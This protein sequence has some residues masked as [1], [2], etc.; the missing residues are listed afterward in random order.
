MR[1]LSCNA[2]NPKGAKF[3]SSCGTHLGIRCPKCG[4]LNPPGARFCN[5]CGH[6]IA[7]RESVNH[8]QSGTAP[9]LSGAEDS[10]FVPEGER[11]LVTA[12]FVDI[13]NSTGLQQDLDPEE[14]RAI[15]DPALRLMIDAVRRYDGHVVQST[16]DGI[17]ALFGA[18]VAHEDHPQRS[19]YTALRLQEEIRRFSDRLRAEGRS[20]IQ[21][22]AGANT[23][24]VVV[25]QIQTGDTQT[26]YT[27]IGHTVNLASRVQA[28]ANA[29]SIVI[30]DETRKLVE[31]YFALR[32]MGPARVKGIS[33]PID[34]YEVTGLGPLRTRLEK[35]AGRGLSKFVGRHKEKEI[36][37][38]AAELARSGSGQIVAVVAEPGV[39]K[40]RLFLEFKTEVSAA[41]T[42]LEAFS[43]SHGKGS[44][45]LPLIEL[46]HSY[47]GITSEDDGSARRERVAMK[48]GRLDSGLEN[49]LPYLHALLE[50]GNEKERLSSMDA[51]LRRSRTLEAVVRLFLSESNRYPLI[52]IVEDLQWLDDESQAVLDLLTESIGTAKVLLLVNYR[53]EY[54]LRWGSKPNCHKIRLESLGHANASEMLSAVL[55]ESR[56]LLPLKQVIIETTGGTPF[57]MEETVQALFDEGALERA[58]GSV[59]LVR[60]LA[61]LRIPPTVQAI[62]AA[63]IDR[64]HNDEKN[65]LQ[66]LAVLG[67]EFVLS[68]ARAVAG[69]SEDELE[70]LIVNLQLGEFVYEQPSI[71][72]VEY[73]FKHALTQEVAYNS[74]LLERRRQL[75]ET[76]GRAIELI[77]SAS[78]DDHV[79]DL[80]HH[81]SRS[82]NQAKAA[83]YLQLAGTQAV[84]RGALAQAVQDFETALSLLKAF[85]SG[86]GR[87]QFELRVLS[88]L[89]TAYI[90]ARGYAAPEVGPVFQRARELCEKIGEPQQR[91]A[92][93]FG[94]FAWRVVRGEMGASMALAL[95]AT[96][97]AERL[98]DPG[99]WME[100]LFLLGV[101]LFYRG[102]FVGAREQYERALSQYDD[103][104]RTRAWAARVGEDA[105]V[106][107]RCYLALALW[108]LGYPEKAL[109]VN[110]E[111]LEIARAIEH[112]FSLAYA[113]H[114]SSWLYHQLRLSDETLALSDEGIRTSAEHGFPLFYATGALYNGAGL[115]LQGQTE[116]ALPALL[117]GFEAYR[118]TGA[119]LALPY[120]LGLLGDA[121][122]QAGVRS[123]AR[124][125]LDN[126]LAIT[127]RS[128]ERCQEAELHRLKGEL[129]LSEGQEPIEVEASFLRAI[130][131]A[132]KQQSKA[133][134]LRATTSLAR[135]YR[136]QNRPDQAREMLGQALG[137]FTEGFVTADL[138][139]ARA[140]LDELRAT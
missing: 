132:K 100:A 45:Y 112:P 16:G 5:K 31:G 34:V 106:T 42:V 54:P 114:H 65:L 113:Q 91:F 115:L 133:W 70:R 47:F 38:R 95:E 82:G 57:F 52:L 124:S 64:L 15:I 40:S 122:T 104:E 93:I 76:V 48:I 62:L 33:E 39:G 120:Y 18:P 111:M 103:R 129:A 101:T 72:D 1:C 2:E 46:L 75:H 92:A 6:A 27:P 25:R 67:R 139:D 89:G 17:F 60:P 80:A 118:A 121:L 107:H 4:E 28:L 19:L 105:G 59:T 14:A 99:V 3:C 126:A 138:R 119:A 102:D 49:T 116:K 128:D 108:H 90:A 44:A 127:E 53:P 77:Y 13:I 83:E 81:F 109:K 73:T 22:R 117:K 140:L 10:Q 35:S 24:E 131:T 71:T 68:L 74:V 8:A 12:L 94:N 11:K 29:G 30:S 87:D 20:P 96:D 134:E 63:R 56:D 79:A 7:V 88:P 130:S 26:E 66:T 84:S 136:R 61:S 58:N 50:I 55:G 78:L 69:K 137:W 51:Q 125:V 23:G 21:I 135:L 86:P 41:W 98:D 123:D 85:P 9:A 37:Q 110:R 32:P 97:L 36:F 43:V